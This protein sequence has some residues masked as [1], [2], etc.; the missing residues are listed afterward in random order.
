MPSM[1]TS[2]EQSRSAEIQTKMLITDI[3]TNRIEVASLTDAQ[4]SR[5]AYAIEN[6]SPMYLSH[7]DMVHFWEIRPALVARLRALPVAPAPTVPNFSFLATVQTWG[8]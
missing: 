1:W 8:A 6:F 5:L 7:S 4:I 3:I 2:N